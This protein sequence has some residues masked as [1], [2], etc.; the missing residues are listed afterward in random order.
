MQWKSV[1]INA[2]AKPIAKRPSRG[3]Y[4]LRQLRKFNLPQ[5]LLKQFYSAIIESV[6]CSSIT[7]WF[8]SANQTS[9]DYS[10]QSGLLRGL[11]VLLCPSSKIFTSPEWGKG[12]ENH[13]GPLTPSPLSLQTVAFWSALQSTDHQNSQAQDMFSPQPIFSLNN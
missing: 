5:E 11:S 1:C 3:C 9:R 4:F 8:G 13:L 7:V 2:S 6:M 12:L 10:G